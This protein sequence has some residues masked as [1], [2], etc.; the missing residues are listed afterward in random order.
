MKGTALLYRLF[1]EDVTMKYRTKNRQNFWIILT[2]CLVSLICISILLPN[3]ADK[4]SEMGAVIN[5]VYPKAYAFD[6][7]DT[8]RKIMDEN[9]VNNGFLE[10]LNN[11]AYKTGAMVLADSGKNINYSPLS[12]YYALALAASGARGDTETELLD[13]LGVQD[14]QTLAEQCGNLYRLLYTDNEIG[15]LKIANSIWMDNNMNGKPVVFK[16][17]F[18]EK[19]AEN[20]YASAHIV[21][22]SEEKTK[23]AMAEWISSNTNGTLSPHIE[24]YADQI[25]SILNTVYFYDQWTYRFD[26]EKTAEDVFYLTDGSEI[27]CDFM[28]RT[29]DSAGFAKGNGFTRAAL[30]LKNAGQMVFILPDEGVSPYELVSS[31]ERMQEAFEGGENFAGKVVWKVPK[32]SFVSMLPMTNILKDLGINRPF[33]TEA[34]FGDITDHLAYI[35]S[36]LQETHV[37]IDENGVEASAYTQIDYSGS[38]AAK[39]EDQAE[40][41]LN[42]PFIYGITAENGSLLFVG[43]CENPKG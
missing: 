4:R 41:V 33:T 1:R 43:I 16:Y 28:N 6:D 8:W 26:R 9:P 38:A 24:L 17:D 22:F 23:K 37:A 35:T 15:K 27:K 19:A 18:V 10:A 39:P 25:L 20:F 21:D 14:K 11:F 42:R 30:S 13:L 36:V 34:D 29:T 5:V 12:L 31:P 40:M 32:F 3:L 7:Y 2:V